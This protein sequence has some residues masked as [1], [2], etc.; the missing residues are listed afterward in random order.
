MFDIGFWEL[1]VIAVVALLVI[2]PDK[3]PGLARTAGLWLGR[4]RHFIGSV[5]ADID[6]ELRADELR[7]ALE[8]DANLDELKQIVNSTRDTIEE[9]T[10]QDYLLKSPD[11]AP[12]PE[13][14]QVRDPE[15]A[16][17]RDTDVDSAAEPRRPRKPPSGTEAR[18]GTRDN[19]H[20][21]ERD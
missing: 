9:S 13:A 12:A 16:A 11:T 3:L 2:G 7:R 20:E 18:Q 8:R 15:P 4:A 1:L 21:Q 10:R 19:T 14:E 6:R 17:P 5:K